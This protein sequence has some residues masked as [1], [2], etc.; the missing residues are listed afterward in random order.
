MLYKI[1]NNNS[2]KIVLII[3]DKEISINRNIGTI[4]F[5]PSGFTIEL[6]SLAKIDPLYNSFTE[7]DYLAELFFKIKKIPNI[8][9]IE[10]SVN[11]DWKGDNSKTEQE[12]L[13]YITQFN[14]D[15][16]FEWEENSHYSYLSFEFLNGKT[17]PINKAT[18]EEAEYVLSIVNDVLSEKI[19]LFN[20]KNKTNFTT[21]V[22]IQKSELLNH[23]DNISIFFRKQLEVLLLQQNTAYEYMYQEDKTISLFITEQYILDVYNM[24]FQPLNTEKSIFD[25]L[26]NKTIEYKKYDNQGLIKIFHNTIDL[27]FYNTH[28]VNKQFLSLF[29]QLA[30][31]IKNKQTFLNKYQTQIETIL[32]TTEI[33]TKKPSNIASFELNHKNEDVKI[34]LYKSDHKTKYNILYVK[35]NEQT[36]RLIDQLPD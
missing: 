21:N 7:S 6:F 14:I 2:Q 12:C 28:I 19:K 22:Y 25:I 18:E 16:V 15:N 13:D 24:L 3:E 8:K 29:K 35:N 30:T 9:N 31:C 36:K 1:K 34:Y 10:F 33:K 5:N 4:D 23:F 26:T 32:T 20:Q 11:Q 27:L 17:Y